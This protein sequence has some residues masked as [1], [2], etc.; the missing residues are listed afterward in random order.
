MCTEARNY[1]INYLLLLIISINYLYSYKGIGITLM[2]SQELRLEWSQQFV[3]G[4]IVSE[5]QRHNSVP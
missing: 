3:Q 5:S 2:Y 1:T 4:H